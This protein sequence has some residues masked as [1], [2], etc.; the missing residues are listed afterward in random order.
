[1]TISVGDRLPEGKLLEMTADGPKEV[2]LAAKFAG[3]KVVVFGLP[4]P[5]SGVCSEAHVP[6]FMRAKPDYDAKGVDEIIC[7]SVND[8]FVVGAWS[9]QTGAGAAGLTLLADAGST[10][11]SALGLDFTAP[12]VG[13]YKRSKRFALYAE[14]GIVKAFELEENPGQC[15]VST[16]ESFLAAI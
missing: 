6:S 1:M 15:A 10:F 5:F 3:R 9:E 14:D 11:I 16:G 8:P 12:A 7:V 13:L 2:D 4:A